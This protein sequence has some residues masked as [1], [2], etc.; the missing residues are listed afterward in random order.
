MILRFFG[1]FD[2]FIN[3][4]DYFC[5]SQVLKEKMQNEIV[6][7]ARFLLRIDPIKKYNHSMSMT[8]FD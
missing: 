6:D 2:L 1:A 5:L 4:L 7:D 3:K 8:N